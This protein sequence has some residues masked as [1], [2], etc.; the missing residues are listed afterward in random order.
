MKTELQNQ[1]RDYAQHVD[2]D[3]QPLTATEVMDVHDRAAA[4]RSWRQQ[5]Q[6]SVRARQGV[7]IALSSA[8]ATILVIGVVAWMVRSGGDV[9]PEQT[10]AWPATESDGLYF[11]AVVTPD[12]FALQQ[13]EVIASPGWE[14]SL[15]YL[16]AHDGHTWL[17]TDGGFTI[18]S[19]G[20][21]A[22][23]LSDSEPAALADIANGR[24]DALLESVA[25]AVELDVAARRGV[26][27]DSP[28]GQLGLD[29]TFTSVLV[30]DGA[31]GLFEIDAVVM[32]RAEILAVA[33]GVERVSFGEARDLLLTLPWT[34]LAAFVHTDFAY[35]PPQVVA[36]VSADYTVV[37]GVDVLQRPRLASA[38]QNPVEALY[39][40]QP[41]QSLFGNI[42]IT[43]HQDLD[44]WQVHTA[45]DQEES[46]AAALSPE[47]T[48]RELAAFHEQA[49]R[50]TLL[51]ED[52]NIV[53]APPGPEP[54]FDP[55]DLGEEIGLVAVT[56]AAVVPDAVTSSPFGARATA[57]HPVVVVG[58]AQALD[59]TADGP[60]LLAYW[61]N[62]GEFC[63]AL[64]LSDG[65][66]STCIFG[67]GQYATY[68]V[69]LAQSGPSGGVLTY[70]VPPQTAVVQMIADDDSYWQKPVAGYGLIPYRN[71]TSR[72]TR[73]VALGA[74]GSEIGHWEISSP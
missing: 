6:S 45:L 3:Q 37:L 18:Y 41:G 22:R 1:I 72:P 63:I 60:I 74:D 53:Q 40:P 48:L 13:A 64:A 42:L 62:T 10:V 25:G 56:D 69:F 71:P 49:L 29:S 73:V 58:R 24:L 59:A 9:S 51:A 44:P 38:L 57:E 43:G 19:S 67:L 15:M 46:L 66:T 17:P 23:D 20:L 70:R 12:G 14:S 55:A 50:G 26:L 36:D 11:A 47:I 65:T 2:G 54:D 27:V 7:W 32:S 28:L 52:P 35:Q 34:H 5:P 39:A 68:G 21:L 8:A 33:V 30:H 31:G 4:V 16:G 61:N